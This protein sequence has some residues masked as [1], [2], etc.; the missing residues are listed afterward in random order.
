MTRTSNLIIGFGLLAV[1]AIAVILLIDPCLYKPCTAD[2]VPSQAPTTGPSLSS[3]Y[4]YGGYRCFEDEICMAV[5]RDRYRIEV[6][7]EFR[8]GTFDMTDDYNPSVDCIWPGSNTGIEYFQ[9]KHPEVQIRKS[10]AIFQT[11]IALFTWRSLLTEL[12]KAG[13]VYSKNGVYYLR[14]QPIV[15]AMIADKQWSEI[16]VSIPGYIRVESTD[17]SSSSSGMLWLEMVGNYLVEGE[18]RNGKVLSGADLLANPTILSKL[19]TYW[20]NQGLQIDTTSKMFSKFISSGVGMPM[21]VAYES[22]YINW[23]EGQSAEM[24][25][26]AAKIVG[27]YPETTINTD[28]TLA[29]L[30]PACDA[31]VDALANDVE[32]QL[33]G[34]QK[35]GMRNGSGGIGAKP[36]SAPWFAESLPY[37]N[38]AKIDVYLAITDMLK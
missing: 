28:H 34:W 8:K 29:S 38:E 16:G 19:Y 27:L 14:M 1:V 5:L 21:I 22:S 25:A 23:F 17:P 32:L 35:H 33:L 26:Q 37:V 15:D 7:G 2:A 6:T 30:S 3:V 12:D 4:V 31:L 9:S 11:P 20:E 36:E 10:A 13:L 18:N 24:Q